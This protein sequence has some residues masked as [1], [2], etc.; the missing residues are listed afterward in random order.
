MRATR[1]VTAC[2][3]PGSPIRRSPDCGRAGAD[4]NMW[5]VETATNRLGRVML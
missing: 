5:F 2:S 3:N 4:K 1:P